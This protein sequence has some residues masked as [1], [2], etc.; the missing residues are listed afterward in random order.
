M[1]ES[2]SRAKEAQMSPDEALQRAVVTD[3]EADAPRLAYAEH[4]QSSSRPADRARGEF[5]RL[6]IELARLTGDEPQWPGLVGRERELLDRYR[7]AWE[8]P[9]R[10]RFRPS[11]LSPGR[12]LRSHLFGSGGLWGF[13]RGFVEHIHAPAPSFLAEDAAILGHAPVRRVVL[14]H[15]SESVGALAA[16][17]RLDA[18]A[19]IHL[20]GHMELDEELNVLAAGARAAGMTVL[21][22]RLPRLWPNAEELFDLLRSSHAEGRQREPEVYP[23]WA[24]AGPDGRRRLSDLSASPR[25]ALLAEDPAHEGELLALNE[26]VYLGDALTAAGAWAV[27]KGHQDLED[28]DRRCRRLVLLRAGRGDELRES[29]YCH[30][31]V[32]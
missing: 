25:L 26:W 13:R 4:L 18:L 5:V 14:A 21:E 19:S 15:A 27:A 12:W 17:P 30:G 3:P 9:L 1:G 11:L 2:P 29:P 31:E 28:E 22:F 8:R 10:D 6:Q 32:G 23:T 20:V 16:D 24:A 7:A